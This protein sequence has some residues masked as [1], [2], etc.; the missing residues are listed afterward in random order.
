MQNGAA[1]VWAK[2][3]DDEWEQVKTWEGDTVWEG[4]PGNSPVVKVEFR[5]RYDG[6]SQN[7][8]VLKDAVFQLGTST[9]ELG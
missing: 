9:P 4:V 6:S 7:Y 1:S 8:A 3:T 2:N 5:K